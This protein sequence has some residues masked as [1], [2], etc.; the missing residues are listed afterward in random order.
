MKQRRIRFTNPVDS[1]PIGQWDEI[2]CPNCGVIIKP[3]MYDRWPVSGQMDCLGC[4]KPFDYA[5]H[6]HFHIPKVNP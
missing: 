5:I 6:A 1:L 4:G 2:N 3:V